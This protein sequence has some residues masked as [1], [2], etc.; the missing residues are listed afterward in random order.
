MR[1]LRLF[2][3]RDI[4]SG[5]AAERERPSLTHRRS[6]HA[7]WTPG[8]IVHAPALPA[9]PRNK[10]PSPSRRVNVDCSIFLAA[11]VEKG[12]EGI[13]M[14]W[15]LVLGTIACFAMTNAA[16]SQS[17][18]GGAQEAI[19]VNADSDP[20]TVTESDFGEFPSILP[21]GGSHECLPWENCPD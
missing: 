4:S 1:L 11:R 3:F 10:L 5:V 6:I 15:W 19:V 17:C 8:V 21:G 14:H 2:L 20:F 13:S 18:D 9:R 16:A 12:E 7:C